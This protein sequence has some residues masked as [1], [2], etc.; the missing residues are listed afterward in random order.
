MP[1]KPAEL[2]ALADHLLENDFKNSKKNKIKETEYPILSPSQL[3][4]RRAREY[5]VSSL[6][7]KQLL[8]A[9]THRMDVEGA[10]S[11]QE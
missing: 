4:R 8:E 9:Q 1:L 11:E 2:E 3:K 5:P 6:S 10:L 7:K